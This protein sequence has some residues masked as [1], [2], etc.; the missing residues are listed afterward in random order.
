MTRQ[1]ALM[2]GTFDPIH[3]G[4]LKV[5]QS[6]YEALHFEKIVFLPAYIP[7][8]KLAQNSSPA[9]DR[10]A[11]VKLA[12]EDYPAFTLEDMEIQKGGLSYTYKTV[13]A[14]RAKHPEYEIYFLIGADSLVQLASWYHIRELLD[15]V[16][17]VVAQRPG[18]KPDSRELEYHFGPGVME[19]LVFINSVRLNISSTAI[20]GLVRAGKKITGLVPPAVEKYIYEHHLYQD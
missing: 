5:A 20:R 8:H 2:G 14:I 1:L 18:Y 17:F 10:L 9:Q 13:E 12:L 16:K 15:E 7:P 4:H 11:M 6:I 19:R 3:M